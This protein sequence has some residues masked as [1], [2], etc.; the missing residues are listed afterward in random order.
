MA[1]AELAPPPAA[2]RSARGELDDLAGLDVDQ[3][4]VVTE[5]GGL[6]AGAAVAELMTLEDARALEQAHGAIDG[7]ERDARVPRACR[8]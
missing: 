6:V 1:E 4:I 5:A 7:R 8:R 3:V 2:A